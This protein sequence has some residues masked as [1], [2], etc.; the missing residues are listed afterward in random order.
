[1][2]LFQFGYSLLKFTPFIRQVVGITAFRI[3]FNVESVSLTITDWTRPQRITARTRAET[4]VAGSRAQASEFYLGDN[5][6]VLEIP[7]TGVG[8]KFV[9]VIGLK[10]ISP[11]VSC[12]IVENLDGT[13]ENDVE[14]LGIIAAGGCSK[15]VLDGNTVEDLDE[16]LE[17]LGGDGRGRRPR[18]IHVGGGRG[19]SSCTIR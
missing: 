15:F 14:V 9:H 18:T 4:R 2:S 16:T 3:H 19:R 10:F 17:R 11:D 1:M 8:V 13:L 5:V 7:A 12:H 6:D